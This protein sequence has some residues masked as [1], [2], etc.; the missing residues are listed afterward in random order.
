MRLFDIM[1]EDVESVPAD[2]S[3]ESARERMTQQQIHHLAVTDRGKVVGVLS[4]GDLSSSRARGVASVREIMS[5][6][7]ATAT[8]NTTIRQAANLLRGRGVGCL[9]V[10]RDESLVGIV[11]V[12][13]LL[14]LIGKGVEHL[15]PSSRPWKEKHRAERPA[16]HVSG[17]H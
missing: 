5:S 2:A 1:S 13:D 6:P 7:V 17:R 10:L 16:R 4:A 11:T 3:L 15:T 12:S 8:P 14:E 9:L